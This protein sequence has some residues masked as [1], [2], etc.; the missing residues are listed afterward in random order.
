M[1]QG[2][3]LLETLT[4]V[5]AWAWQG[6]RRRARRGQPE[7]L[8]IAIADHFEPSFRPEAPQSFADRA[9]QERR[10]AEW[11]REY[12]KAVEAW[13]DAD[14]VPL[15]HTYFYPAEQH[16]EALVERLA[17]HCHEGWGEIEI[18]LHHGIEAPDTA[19]N[20]RRVLC[21]FRDALAR[22][23]CLARADAAGPP[24]YAFVHGN[25]ALANS[26]GGRSCGVDDEMQILA[27]TGCYAD[28][29]LPSAPH[30]AQT[31]KINALY[32]CTL[33][34]ERRAP[35]RRGQD[36]R[37]GR[38][39]RVFPLIVQGPL[40]FNWSRRL[41]GWPVPF[42]E[43]GQLTGLVPPTTYRVDLWRGAGIGVEGRPE[44]S[45]IKLH[46]HGMDPRDREA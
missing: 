20:T 44:W 26:F 9:E 3:K 11:C 43:N 4:W 46:C 22:H 27:D 21:E 7:H 18:H 32:E 8:I 40:G 24:R 31:R 29:T 16:D 33:P 2:R 6:A 28:M 34:L 23:G 14:G 38:P 39:P 1:S 12:P 10:L 45:F 13:R 17:E 15:R 5:P 41:R 19:E 37:V 42:I 36:L 35:H 25:W 30:P